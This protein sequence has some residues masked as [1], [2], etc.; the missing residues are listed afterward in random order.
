MLIDDSVGQAAPPEPGMASVVVSIDNTGD[1]CTLSGF[2]GIDLTTSMGHT[3][4]QHGSDQPTTVTLARGGRTTFT[5]WYHPNPPGQV[6]ITVHLLH[7]TP[8]G[9]TQR[10][11][12]LWPGTDLAYEP[13]SNATAPLFEEP[14]GH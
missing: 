14:V 2:A 12:M 9:G 5:I 11:S 8:P 10:Q 1:T 6:G 13:G 3:P 7:V 4:V